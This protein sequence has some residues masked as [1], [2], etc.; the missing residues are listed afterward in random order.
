MN[1]VIADKIVDI[2]TMPE[3][4]S[5]YGYPEKR[6]RRIPCPIHHGKDSNFCYTDKVFHCWTCG[7]KGNVIGFVMQNFRLGFGQA[8]LKINTDFS[9]GLTAKKPTL[10]ERK[11]QV[12]QRRLDTAYK[13]WRAELKHEYSIM[14][15]A[16]AILFRQLQVET[17]NKLL[18]EYVN[19]LE[20]WLDE[21]I[22]EVRF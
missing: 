22:E 13:K 20:L 15:S 3:V 4:L 14:A 6:G 10:R 5:R 12:E 17:D 21:N 8:L 11:S 2:I 9:L 16:H 7:A 19:K 18:E 1:N